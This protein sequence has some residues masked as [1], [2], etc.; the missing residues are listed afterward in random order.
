MFGLLDIY[1]SSLTL[2]IR[3]FS[4]FILMFMLYVIYIF[5]DLGL[6]F[7]FLRYL[8][9]NLFLLDCFIYY[10]KTLSRTYETL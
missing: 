4:P 9:W 2:N 10:E 1:K 3:L 6:I 8:I 7:Y 5:S